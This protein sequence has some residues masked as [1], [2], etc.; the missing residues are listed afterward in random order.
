MRENAHEIAREIVVCGSRLHSWQVRRLGAFEDATRVHA[1][2]AR[3]T[4]RRAPAIQC[5]PVTRPSSVCKRHARHKTFTSVFRYYCRGGLHVRRACWCG[6]RGVGHA[7]FMNFARGADRLLASGR[8]W[9]ERNNEQRRGPF[10]N[11]PQT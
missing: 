3:Q 1:S 2:L 9:L 11:S 4:F 5:Y 7:A 10:L 6:H 8:A